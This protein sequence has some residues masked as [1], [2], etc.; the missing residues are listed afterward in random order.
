[1]NISAAGNAI[2]TGS[3]SFG[4]TDTQPANNNNSVTIGAK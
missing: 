2:A 1:V 3:A 4:G